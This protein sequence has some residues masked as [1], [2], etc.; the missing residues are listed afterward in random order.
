MARPDPE[1]PRK[2]KNG[3]ANIF[4][5][6]MLVLLIVGLAGF[7]ITNF[8]GGVTSVGRVGDRQITVTDYANALRAEM[9]AFSAQVG[10]P[11]S[12]AQ[13][14]A[15]GLDRQVRQQ[16][17]TQA[18]LDNEAARIGVSAGDARVAAEITDIP[19]FRG[20]SGQ[21]DRDA[22]RFTLERNNLREAE[23][24]RRLRD[25]LARSILQGA[26][27]G[28]F[29][30]PAPL[31]DTL[32]AYV[33]ER[34]GFSLL[35]LTEGDLEGPLPDPTEADLTAHYESNLAAFTRPEARRIEYATLLPADLAPTMTVDDTALRRLYDERITDFVQPE[36][37]LV[38]RLVMADQAAAE[39]AMARIAEGATFDA[40]VAERGLDLADT[41]MG[42]MSLLDLGAAGPAIFA[43]EEPGVVGPFASPLGPA[44]FR[45]NGVLPAQEI[46]FDE[47]RDDLVAELASDVARRA[48]ADR[49]DTIDDLLAGGAEIDELVTDEGMTAGMIDLVPASDDPI[50]GYPAFRDAAARAREGDFP[51]LVDLADGGL[52][53]LRLVEVLPPAPLP[54]DEVRDRVAQSW[55]AAEVA[56][57]LADRATAIKAE[58]EGGASLGAYGILEVTPRIARDGFV[59]GAP[60]AFMEAVFA[61]QPGQLRVIEGPGFV[62]VLRLDSQVP[63]D[64][65]DAGL[66]TLRTAIAAQA[67]AA[68]AQDA[69]A[70]FTQ[71]L[72]A[73]AGIFFDEQALAAVHAQMQ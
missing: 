1:T 4:V 15:L 21:F 16:L 71:A 22:Y 56:S 73:N 70:L 68:L 57:R 33:G 49:R 72:T 40:L 46:T 64:P 11:V 32:F 17:V 42:D 37:R 67:E 62:G 50:A 12:F 48:I 43:L 24:E 20:P 28:G 10:Q 30:A 35:R 27:S 60:A 8:G 18:A 36:R 58:V 29:A 54:L 61:M 53:V 25:D 59:E 26:M 2:K 34:R 6:I 47:A 65:E 13:A 3:I 7:S 14:Q 38:E 39:A 31:T 44:I 9:S 51:V 52:V 69:F 19:A 55:R 41:D 45:M 5:W 63:A 23:F 66:A